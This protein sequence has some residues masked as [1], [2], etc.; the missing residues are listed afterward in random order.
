MASA[1]GMTARE[2]Y[3]AAFD[4]RVEAQRKSLIILFAPA[5]ALVLLGLFAWRTAGPGVPRRYGEHLV[6]A[7]HVLAFVWLVFAAW[8]AIAALV[9]GRA[10]GVAG[11]AAVY[12]VVVALVLAA[13]VYVFGAVRRAYDL[14]LA[15]AL[16]VTAALAAAFV[17]LLV[18]YRTLLFVTTYYTL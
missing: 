12:A 6:F 17:G 3:V 1:A 8:G 4:G 16:A 13:P 5:L 2:A 7:L 15:V 10:L 14:S 18:V 9:H 11:S